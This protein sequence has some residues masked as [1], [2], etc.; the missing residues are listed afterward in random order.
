MFI[1]TIRSAG[2]DFRTYLVAILVLQCRVLV[3]FEFVDIF[4][5]TSELSE[6]ASIPLSY[7]LQPHAPK[8]ARHRDPHGDRIV[9]AS[10]SFIAK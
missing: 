3:P 5:P 9:A 1:S 4:L 10:E 6:A 2:G 8:R 7:S